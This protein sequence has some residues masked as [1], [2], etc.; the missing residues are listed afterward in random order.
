MPVDEV[1][2]GDGDIGGA[3]YEVDV[4]PGVH[5][6]SGLMGPREHCGQRIEAYG[7]TLELGGTRFEAAGEIRVSPPANLNEQCIEAMSARGSDER[8]NR[9]W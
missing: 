6:Q 9:V 8:G 4:H 7:L 2:R 1:T 5:A 3:R